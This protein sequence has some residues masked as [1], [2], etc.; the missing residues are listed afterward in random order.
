MRLALAALVLTVSTAAP[1]GTPSPPGAGRTAASAPVCRHDMRVR[2]V[3]GRPVARA[4]RLGE[5]PPADL[6]LSVLNRVG[7]CIE[8]V[9]VRQG[10]GAMVDG[11]GR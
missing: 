10:Y 2:P 6:T 8:P 1:A 7:E 11:T 9:T 4:K 3:G 5:L